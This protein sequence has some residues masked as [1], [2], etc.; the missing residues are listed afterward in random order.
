MVGQRVKTN[1]Q[2]VGKRY[3]ESRVKEKNLQ[4]YK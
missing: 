1:D 2:L 4:M 3:T